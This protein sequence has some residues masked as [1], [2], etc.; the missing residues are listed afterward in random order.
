MF[1]LL[2]ACHDQVKGGEITVRNDIMDEEY[3]SFIVDQI[4]TSTGMSSHSKMLKP[5]QEFKIPAKRIT[6]MR[7]TRRYKDHSNVYII[8]CPPDADRRVM[9]KLLDVHTN[10]IAGGCVL[11]RRGRTEAGFTRWEQ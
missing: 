8:S 3:N 10:K 9:I 1:L 11:T 7:F 5:G 2:S 4:K 6:G